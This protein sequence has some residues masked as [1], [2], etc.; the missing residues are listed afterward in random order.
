MWIIIISGLCLNLCTGTGIS[1]RELCTHIHMSARTCAHTH[2]HT[3]TEHSLSAEL[4]PANYPID[5]ACFCVSLPHTR[6]SWRSQHC[7]A[8]WSV[9]PVETFLSGTVPFCLDRESPY[10]LVVIL[11]TK[12]MLL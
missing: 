12:S 11:Y 8:T 7:G 6:A 3:H 5:T 9:W 4:H 2:T 1:C 10:V